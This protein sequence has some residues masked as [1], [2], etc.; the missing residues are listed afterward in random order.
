LDTISFDDIDDY[1]NDKAAGSLID[2]RDSAVGNINRKFGE[3]EFYHK[4]KVIDG[5]GNEFYALIST[6]EIRKSIKR[7]IKKEPIDNYPK[8]N[9][10]RK[11]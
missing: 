6:S 4:V 3:L 10:V 8:V 9:F 7:T 11:P 1:Q 2:L 5:V